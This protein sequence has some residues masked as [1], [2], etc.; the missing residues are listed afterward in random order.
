MAW[1]FIW[2][3]I[4][5]LCLISGHIVYKNPSFIGR[6]RSDASISII[7]PARNEG[8]NLPKLLDSIGRQRLTSL[9][10]IVADDGSTDDT[11]KIAEAS[12]ATVIEVP[13]GEWQ[14]KSHACHHGAQHARYGT[15]VFMDA[16]TSF[17]GDDSLSRISAQY[18]KQ[19]GRG[20][21]SIQPFHQTERFH[22]TFSAIFNIVTVTGMNIFSAFGDRTHTSTVFGPFLMTG[23][24]DYAAT[25]GHMNAKETIIEGM[26]IYRGY[27][28]KG[29]PTTLYMGYDVLQFRMYP[30]GLPSVVKG[31]TKHIAS[32]A[33]NTEGWVMALIMLWLSGTLIAP[34]YLVSTAIWHFES[35]LWPVVF[36]I[37]Y[38]LQFRW[39]SRRLILLPWYNFFLYPLYSLFFFHVYGL[40][41]IQ[42]HII[43]KVEWKGRKV[44]LKKRK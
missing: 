10:V 28:E 3:S 39:M 38:A 7:V 40:S 8:H 5:I 27:H 25:G 41:F 30:E 16:D 18:R 20:V 26:G 23:R 14:G 37:L 6:S 1:H 35:I 44:D 29:L 21:L 17:T 36:Y 15:L 9:E 19:G 22:E 32:G 2:I 31:W 42:T 33:E 13:E 12:G 4:L 34:A 11:R 43:K 24:R